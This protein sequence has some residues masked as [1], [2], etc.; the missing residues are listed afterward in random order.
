MEWLAITGVAV[1]PLANLGSMSGSDRAACAEPAP[2]AQKAGP[3]HIIRTNRWS[4]VTGGGVT[5]FRHACKRDFSRL[6]IRDS[7]PGLPRDRRGC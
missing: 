2:P 6:G 4:L 5:Q 3:A 7:N 1:G